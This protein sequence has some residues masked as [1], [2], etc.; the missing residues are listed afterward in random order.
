MLQCSGIARKG[1]LGQTLSP[2]VGDVHSCS[3]DL[4]GGKNRKKRA[5][6][7]KSLLSRLADQAPK[8]RDLIRNHSMTLMAQI[9]LLPVWMRDGAGASPTFRC[10]ERFVAKFDV[11]KAHLVSR[12]EKF[13]LT[14]QA[15][16]MENH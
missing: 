5:K 12:C 8:V 11:D 1:S 2:Q 14:T 13:I 7:H 15:A 4:F 3:L 16:F 6:V 9:D 10:M